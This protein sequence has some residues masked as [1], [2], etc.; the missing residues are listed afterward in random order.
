MTKIKKKKRNSVGFD[1]QHCQNCSQ[2]QDCPVKKGKKFYYLR[3]SEKEM[4]IPMELKK[5]FNLEG[6]CREPFFVP[7]TKRINDL[8]NELRTRSSH[9][10]VIVDEYGGTSGIVTVED[11]VEEIVGEIR[12]EH[13]VE[14]DPF[15]AQEDGSVLVSA[16]VGL[17]DFEEHFGVALPREGYDTLGG[18]IIHAMGSIASQ[19]SGGLGKGDPFTQAEQDVLVARQAVQPGVLQDDVQGAHGQGDR[20][21]AN[22]GRLCVE[23]VEGRRHLGIV[24][25]ARL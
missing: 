16:R 19:G 3:F 25:P 24:L 2:L 11:I 22:L 18:F 4:R 14:E 7:E 9:L 17:D 20:I 21:C 6:L 1:S 5:E 13:D 12:D 15:V 8:L 10:A 23:R